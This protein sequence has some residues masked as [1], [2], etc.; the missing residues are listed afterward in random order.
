MPYSY[1]LIKVVEPT[2]RHEKCYSF[3][4]FDRYVLNF[5]ENVEERD[6]CARGFN[7]N[8]G[9]EQTTNTTDVL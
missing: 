6:V 3:S 7:C 8:G 4:V 2:V 9:R 1:L 5:A